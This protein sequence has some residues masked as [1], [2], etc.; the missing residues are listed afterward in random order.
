LIVGML[1]LKKYQAFTAIP[2]A[3][4]LILGTILLLYR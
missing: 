4:F 3:P 1:F 2:Y